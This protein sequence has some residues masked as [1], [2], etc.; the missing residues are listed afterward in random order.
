MSTAKD[1]NWTLFT[2]NKDGWLDCPL[3]ECGK[4][5]FISDGYRVIIDTLEWDDN[6]Y[7]LDASNWDLIGLAW[8]PLPE[9][10]NL[11]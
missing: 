9:P 10:R 6:G 7:Y 2:V 8:M 11:G 4:E 1:Q 5:I 3:P